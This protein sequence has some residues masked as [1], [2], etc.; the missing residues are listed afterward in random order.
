MSK[1]IKKY[2]YTPGRLPQINWDKVTPI[3]PKV[4]Y[5]GVLPSN[6]G[7]RKPKPKS[8]PRNNNRR[9]VTSKSTTQISGNNQQPQ[10]TQTVEAHF[11]N[12]K[13]NQLNNEWMK[14][15]RIDI[16]TI[17]DYITNQFK[18]ISNH[19]PDNDL[20]PYDQMVK[21]SERRKQYNWY[22]NHQNIFDEMAYNMQKIPVLGS[23]P[24]AIGGLKGLS[25]Y[26]AGNKGAADYTWERS[27]ENARMQNIILGGLLA[28][29][30]PVTGGIFDGAMLGTYAQD[31]DKEGKFQHPERLSKEEYASLGLSSI[32]LLPVVGKNYRVMQ[33]LGKQGTGGGIEGIT[34]PEGY[35]YVR[36]LSL[37][38]GKN[39][40]V[41]NVN[42][43]RE[44]ATGK[45]KILED[46]PQAQE[47]V[48]LSKYKG[49]K[50]TGNEPG[51]DEWARGLTPE[52]DHFPDLSH[53][54]ND[55]R[56]LTAIMNREFESLP[57]GSRVDLGETFS[58]DSSGNLLQY[59]YRHND[60]IKM[61]LPEYD[62]VVLTNNYGIKGKR[63]ADIFNQQLD[64][65]LD[66]Y[67]YS[68][69]A[70]PKATYN[71]E[72]NT[73]SVPRISFIKL[74]RNGNKLIKKWR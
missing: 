15:Q 55:S 7:R 19:N 71:A 10:E 34:V 74:H 17:T 62:D 49:E 69:D 47:R 20:D 29:L 44:I 33:Q 1:L 56:E 16:P 72:T 63:S 73:L 31:L 40:Q 38:S 60:R 67:G 68:P 35:E 27:A 48:N 24:V 37:R 11:N 51:F 23:I 39:G 57:N 66:H 2:Q 46:L 64:R 61:V 8:N 25:Q 13:L 58:G 52:N 41:R 45:Y 21:E 5:D 50:L 42:Q 70:V 14:H 18:T 43:V 53:G 32:P 59:V 26:L 30:N 54:L 65:L 22:K 4:Q 3:K 28:N 9:K 6:F 36:P 12:E